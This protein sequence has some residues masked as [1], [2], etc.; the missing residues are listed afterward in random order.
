VTGGRVA[1]GTCAAVGLGAKV[2]HN[3]RIGAHAVVGAGA[4]VLQD[5]PDQVVAYGTPARVIRSRG[6][7][8]PYL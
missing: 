6:V 1:L 5:V 3:V 4:L 8:D 7:D 2:V